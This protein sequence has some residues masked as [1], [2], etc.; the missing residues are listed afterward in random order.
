MGRRREGRDADDVI[1]NTLIIFAHSYFPMIDIGSM[2]SYYVSYIFGNL[3]IPIKDTFSRIS[4]IC[5]LGQSVQV[6]RFI[7]G[8]R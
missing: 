1:A 3:G 6:V 4:V 8:F 2:H 5:P 7:E